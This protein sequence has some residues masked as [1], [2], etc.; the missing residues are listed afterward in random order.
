MSRID[1]YYRDRLEDENE[2]EGGGGK[3]E[4]NPD[5]DSDTVPL[6][7]N[8]AITAWNDLIEWIG[9]DAT[10]IA[11]L[12]T[13][14]GIVFATIPAN[15]DWA[16]DLGTIF[17]NAD[18]PKGVHG[19]IYKDVLDSVAN[20]PNFDPDKFNELFDY[21]KLGRAAGWLGT[22]VGLYEIWV[23]V[24][25]IRDNTHGWTAEEFVVVLGDLVQDIPDVVFMLWG[26]L[27]QSIEA[28]GSLE[29]EVFFEDPYEI[30]N[31]APVPVTIPGGGTVRVIE[32]KP[33]TIVVDPVYPPDYT[34]PEG[35]WVDD[36]KSAIETVIRNDPRFQHDPNFYPNPAPDPLAPPGVEIT[37]DPPS[38]DDP[39][40]GVKRSPGQ[41]RIRIWDPGL[42]DEPNTDPAEDRRL[43][44][45]IKSSK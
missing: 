9:D 36:L 30:W 20:D 27:G 7:W 25:W 38:G 14:L 10:L 40:K 43:R 39:S 18:I 28:L 37:I 11:E 13:V 12:E 42:R 22:L 15:A 5:V 2:E 24:D 35:D 29:D 31:P 17:D 21:L 26:Y 33:G 3:A 44:H 41:I 1:D 34:P 45:D 16:P 4:I 23:G 6:T 8:D 19:D 32:T